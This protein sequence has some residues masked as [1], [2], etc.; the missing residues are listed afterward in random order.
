[1]KT[2]APLQI[3]YNQRTLE[4]N[5]QFHWVV[6]PSLYIRISTGKVELQHDV[7]ADVMESMGEAPMP[8]MGMPKPKGE[9]IL[10]GSLFAPQGTTTNAGQASVTLNGKNKTINVFGDRH[11]QG[12]IPSAPAD[13]ESMPL[14]Y[15]HA[16]G[17]AEFANNP[18]G[19]GYKTEQLPNLES[20]QETITSNAKS[21]TPAGF[22]ALDPSW[23]Q[24][25]QYQ[26][27]YDQHYLEKFFPG[28]PQDMDWKLFMSSQQDQW[29]DGFFQGNE[30][31]ELKN[32]HPQQSVQQ[33]QLPGLFPRCFIKDSKA[34]ELEQFKEVDLHLDTIWFFP[35]KDVIQLIWRG[36]MTVQDDEA[37]Q[38]SHML[39]AYES[40]HDQ[41]REA[42][43][44]RVAMERRINDPDPL[45]DSLNTSDLIP[46]G[47]ASAMQLLQASAL[48]N[49]QPS[50]M[51]Q[52]LESKAETI[53]AAV[54]E[55][56]E[57]SLN[58]LKK[59]LESPAVEQ[60]QR[61]QI[62]DQLAQLD[63]PAKPDDD[64]AALLAKLEE[65]LPGLTSDNPK[66]LDLS[67]FSFKKIDEIF[68]EIELFTAEQKTKMLEQAKPQIEQLTAQ[69]NDDNIN[70]NLSEEQRDLIQQ[71]LDSLLNLG[72]EDIKPAITEL[73][74][75][76]IETIKQQ[77]AATTP[78]I[79]KAKQELHLMLSNPLLSNTEQIQQAKDKLEQLQKNE[80]AAIDQ[81][82]DEANKQ[83]IESYA[84]GAHFADHG[85]SPHADD[86]VQK[87]KL[88]AI[89]NGDKNAS[90]QDWACLDL[91]GQNLDGMN[92]SHC[93][94]EQ[95]NLTG[96]S[97]IGANFEGTV[98]ARANLNKAN[99]TQANFNKANIGASQCNGTRF[100]QC[101]FDESKF[102]KA[103]FTACSFISANIIQ[104][105]ALEIS[106]KDCDF[107]SAK[108]KNFPFLE[109]T[110]SG[111]DFSHA[112]LETCNFVNSELR[113]CKFKHSKLPST[114]WANTSVH[115][116]SFQYADM[117]SNCFVSAD[118]DNPCTFS[119]LDFSGAKLEKANFSNLPLRNSIFSHCDMESANFSGADLSNSNFDDCMGHKV[120]FRKANLDQASMKRANLMEAVMAKAIITHTDLDTANLYGVDFLR[121]TVKNTRFHGA[122][123]D[124][125]ILKD[126]RPS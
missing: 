104:P 84:M 33:G 13:F 103:E 60:D 109:L 83:F 74:R 12:T 32:M 64:S 44:Y 40:H 98:L 116:T 18:L 72:N 50:A 97:L 80:L 112:E 88:L 10:N 27:T 11:W 16:F 46:L 75:L 5:K 23:P 90:G 79:D 38:I 108:I 37:E 70:N 6:S 94:M 101:E 48:E 91:S 95:V 123:L 86:D 19:S 110:L 4:Q 28:Y 34:P 122:N 69:L 1:M 120:M 59:Q 81:Q 105:E 41:R 71:Q 57:E 125:T 24:R 36:G 124:A 93:L 65:I 63:Q 45:Q 35:D 9:W 15:Q 58:D 73:P 39:L 52:N 106:I 53:K 68:A 113:S 55:K 62:L 26:G 102:S 25:M 99:C 66:D 96:A 30:S 85:L 7:I 82:L 100:D 78:E 111:I 47:A 76:D 118:E 89:M 49:A 87:N 21:Y 56:V 31:F 54:D 92:F 42:D 17:G 114:A 77:V 43:H 2:F 22:A 51:Q 121:A 8:D 61:Q 20:S 119:G 14:D 29:I 3:A 117:T 107:S 67:D 115:S 126:W